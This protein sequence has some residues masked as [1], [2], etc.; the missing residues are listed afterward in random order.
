[1]S[2]PSMIRKA[3]LVS[4]LVLMAFVT[5]HLANLALGLSSLATVEHWQIVLM[6]PWLSA[7]GKILLAGAAFVHAALGLYALAARRS[8]VLS[9]SDIVQLCLGLLVPPL[10]ISH[11]LA[12]GGTGQLVQQF[13]VSYSLILAIY[14]VYSPLYAFQQLLVVVVVWIHGALGIYGWLVLKPVWTRIGGLVLPILFAVPILALLGFAEAGKEV[15]A[16]LLDDPAWQAAI[17][18]NIRRMISVKAPLYAMQVQVLTIYGTAAL[19]ALAILA[20]RIFRARRRPISIAYDGGAVAQGRHGLSILEFSRLNS[21]AHAH[22]C[23]GRGRC[24]TCRVMVED[25]AAM[26]SPMRGVERAT[27]ARIHA[28]A[29]VR[30]ACQARVLGPGVAVVRLLPAFVDAAAARAPE[31]WSS[32]SAVAEAG[33]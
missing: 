14:W 12:I 1:M 25:G 27:L 28:G 29:G 23:S 24:G 11:V 9:A 3:R 31:E 19:L 6:G 10:L 26:L 4:G 16:R 15:I 22:V 17:I 18:A 13:Q 7:P 21:I 33:A 2:M 5:C 30:L 32:G 8:L 20:A